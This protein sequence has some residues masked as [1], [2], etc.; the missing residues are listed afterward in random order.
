MASSSNETPT[1]YLKDYTEYP[2]DV[3]NVRSPPAM[4]PVINSEITREIRG[5][6]THFLRGGGGVDLRSERSKVPP[7]VFPR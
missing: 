6:R 4:A 7:N 1:T 5:A 2:Y 3:E